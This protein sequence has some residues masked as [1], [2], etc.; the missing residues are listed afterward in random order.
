MNNIKDFLI[1]NYIWVLVVILLCIITVIGFLAD[2]QKNK[3]E[4]D[5]IDN[6]NNNQ[7]TANIPAAPINYQTQQPQQMNYQQN[8][9]L[10]QNNMT[11]VQMPMNNFGQMPNTN[12]MPAN[13]NMTGI[14]NFQ[15][16]TIPQPLPNQNIEMQQVNQN[17][18]QSFENPMI[19]NINNQTQ[20]N[21]N[22]NNPQPIENINATS[23]INQ[24]SMY[25]PLSEQKPVFAPR[26]INATIPMPNSQEPI[27]NSQMPL[28]NVV[29][30]PVENINAI[31][32]M[33]QNSN[34]NM[35]SMIYNQIP[36][37]NAW[38]NPGQ[39]MIMNQ[40]TQMMP[41]SQTMMNEQQNTIP[42]PVTEPKPIPT[43]SAPINFVF[44]PQSNNNQNM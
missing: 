10:G 15:T 17:M 14:E 9:Q 16:N 36:Q 30:Q 4:K 26:E 23:N 31:P 18:N 34:M 43:Q 28:G 29:P 32:Q 24:E 27:V 44:G 38:N 40:N 5:A 42:N 41:N 35:N 2:K 3:K 37:D 20:M 7:N 22:V 19:N 33:E 25:Q 39:T 11:M 21:N 1:D 13:Q 12:I 6:N 8:G